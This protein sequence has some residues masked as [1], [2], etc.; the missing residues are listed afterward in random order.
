MR[1]AAALL[2][3]LCA[4]PLVRAQK[5]A[6]PKADASNASTPLGEK[7]SA[8]I[9]NSYATAETWSLQAMAM[10]SLGADWHPVASPC[11]LSA[12][13]S[14]DVKLQV[15][16]LEQ[17]RRT[18]DRV[19]GAVTTKE[20]V[21]E[22]VDKLV[23]SKNAFVR[24]RAV[25]VLERVLPGVDGSKPSTIAKWWA[26]QRETYATKP[27]TPAD[28]AAKEGGTAAG[29]IM[30]KAF[31][32]RDAGLQVVFVVDSTGSMQLAIDAVRD[33]IS[34]IAAI[35]GGIAPKLELG[36]VHYKDFGDMGDP[37][38]ALVPLTKNVKVVREK[39]AK[40]RAGGG[41][42][43]PERVEHGVQVA[44]DKS[45]GWDKEK[46]RMLL[47]VGDAPPHPD[48]HDGLI[49]LVRGAY[50]KP[51]QDPKRPVTGKQEK[52]K[53]FITS[54]I[55]TSPRANPWF[56]QIAEA[57]GGTMVLLDMGGPRPGGPA[58]A[59]SAA[60]PVSKEEAPERIA[61]HVL[62]LSFGPQFAAQ[63]D[64]FVDTFFDYRRAGAF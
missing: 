55:A 2:I 54:T 64:V 31:D 29:G 26:Q 57:G 37:A 48:V 44:L 14:K 41:G 53:P 20:M 12:L 28:G 60:K 1:L 22:V 33:A 8:T 11:L 42:D 59:A 15:Y 19:L 50:E 36:L 38:E 51:F 47:V 52:L 61:K 23:A 7:A 43:E 5:P 10:L 17:L 39:L 18:N 62:R 21:D 6:E 16:A 25:E 40:L 63:I 3:S 46:N 34:E 35:L 9:A 24:N 45:M 30:E 58:G 27:W 49:G 13:A 32:L 56:E 4:A